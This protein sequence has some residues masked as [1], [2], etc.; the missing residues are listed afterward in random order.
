MDIEG[1]DPRDREHPFI[2][3]LSVA[4][5]DE[6]VRRELAERRSELAASR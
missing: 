1:G 4:R 3:D 5:D 6:D 2:E